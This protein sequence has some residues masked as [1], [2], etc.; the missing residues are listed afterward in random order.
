MLNEY[1]PENFFQ[2]IIMIKKGINTTNQLKN[3]LLNFLDEYQ[4]ELG[5]KNV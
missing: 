2:K 5:E 1:R 3:R 4:I